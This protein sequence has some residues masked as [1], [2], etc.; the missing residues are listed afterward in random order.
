MVRLAS[1]PPKEGV[2]DVQLLSCRRGCF[3]WNRLICASVVFFLFLVTYVESFWDVESAR[4]G[5]LIS[6]VDDTQAGSAVAC[7]KRPLSGCCRSVD[8]VVRMVIEC[9][10]RVRERKKKSMVAF[11][12]C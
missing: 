6:S 12:L 9:I 4:L 8:S 11:R 3:E 10:G 5:G 7:V 2:V 1:L